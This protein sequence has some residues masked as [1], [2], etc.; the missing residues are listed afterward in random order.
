MR[1]ILFPHKKIRPIQDK[2]IEK[3]QYC[4]RNKKHLIAHAPTGIGKTAVLGPIL[5]YAIRNKLTVFFLTPRHM[6]HKIAIDTIRSIKERYNVNIEAVDLIGKKWM[7]AQPGIDILNS[8]EF[9]EYCKDL[10]EK[11]TCIYH[12]N[13]LRDK[14]RKELAINNL[15]RLNPLHVEKSIEVNKDSGLCPFE[16]SCLMAKRADLIIA[17]YYHVLSPSIR[18]ILFKK[19]NKDLKNSIIIFDEAHN[20]ISRGR[21]LL[22]WNLSTFILDQA[23]RELS[24]F[25]YQEY[26]ESVEEIKKILESLAKIMPFDELE[27]NYGKLDFYNKIKNYD[28]LVDDFNFIANEIREV[29]KRSFVGSISRFLS[30]WLGEDEGFVRIFRRGFDKKGKPYLSLSYRC[31][32]PSVLMKDLIEEAHSIISFSG[33]L[34]PTSM[35]KDLLGFREVEEVE[36]ENP[37]PKEN[38]LTMIVPE[39]T[40]KFTMRDSSMF[41]KISKTIADISNKI[42]GNVAV[43]FPSYKLRDVIYNYF[44]KLCDKTIFLERPKLTKKDKE[45]LIDNFKKY[46]DSGA[47][48]LGAS[49]GNFGEGIDLPGDYLKGVIVVGLPLA[50]PNL[51]TKALINYYDVKFSKGWDYGYI[52]PAILRTLQNAGRCIR[53]E[54]DKGIVVFLDERYVWGNYLKCFPPDS[55]VQITKLPLERI[56]EFINNHKNQIFPSHTSNPL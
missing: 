38:K 36:F 19:M 47:V 3:V 6:Q 9:G 16:M 2:L 20:L 34:N 1:E 33:T 4:I 5:A 7:C 22:T 26:I 54:T 23:I 15:K 11:E 56:E 12:N 44:S 51:E 46:K 45:E 18:N 49:S 31:L 14:V 30:A 25:G 29:K 42:E 13:F 21:D 35:Y 32:D 40:T 53:S 24:Q 43:F 39:T 27:I 41:K 50:K 48:L 8:G 55:N 37:F 17:D 10:I 52:Y 28:Q